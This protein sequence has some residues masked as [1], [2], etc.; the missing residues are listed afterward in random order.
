MSFFLF[1]SLWYRYQLVRLSFFYLNQILKVLPKW[2][3]KNIHLANWRGIMFSGAMVAAVVLEDEKTVN[4]LLPE[5]E[6]CQNAL[7]DDGSYGESLQYG[8]YLLLA[9]T[10]AK[11][12]VQRRFP[13][14]TTHK[15]YQLVRNLNVLLQTLAR[16]GR[17][18]QSKSRQFQ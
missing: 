10:F 13:Q 14:L 3:D 2:L 12:A 6:L 17:K 8:N 15:F 9:I 5:F 4:D 1:M 18:T 11:E 7:Q 16:L